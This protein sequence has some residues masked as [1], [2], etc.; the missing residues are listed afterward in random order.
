MLD[1]VAPPLQP[2]LYVFN[3]EDKIKM[4]RTPTMR[5]AV[6]ARD[7]IPKLLIKGDFQKK[8]I[9]SYLCREFVILL[10]TQAQIL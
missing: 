10:F 9:K 4:N 8:I 5:N 1:H 3:E 6:N 7:N 2:P